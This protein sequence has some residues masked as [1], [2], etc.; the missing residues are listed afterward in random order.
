MMASEMA[1]SSAAAASAGPSDAQSFTMGADGG[2]A[3]PTSVGEAADVSTDPRE[4]EVEVLAPRMA[5]TV[6][7]SW[8][9]FFAYFAI[10]QRQ[11]FQVM[12]PATRGLV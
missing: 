2:Y 1:A 5:A 12:P 10:Y 8:D 9:A 11:T 7:P 3:A 4:P 6:F